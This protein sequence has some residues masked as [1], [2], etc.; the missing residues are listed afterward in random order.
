[1]HGVFY[2]VFQGNL[3]GEAGKATATQEA[4]GYTKPPAFVRMVERTQT[5]RL[6]DPHDRTPVLQNIGVDYSS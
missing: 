6:P 2:D 1:M 5:S 3:W 4:G